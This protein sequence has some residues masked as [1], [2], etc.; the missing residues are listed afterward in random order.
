[1]MEIHTTQ[2]A[3]QFYSGNFLDGTLKAGGKTYGIH[4]TG[5][6]KASIIPTRQIGRA[7]HRR[8]SGLA[9]RTTSKPCTSFAQVAVVVA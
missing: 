5:A 8:C 1:M 7:S 9:K 4:G 3:I 6:S 2:P